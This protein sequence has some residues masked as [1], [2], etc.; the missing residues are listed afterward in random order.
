MQARKIQRVFRAYLEKKRKLV[1]E[2]R[3]KRFKDKELAGDDSSVDSHTTTAST[4]PV[5]SNRLGALLRPIVGLKDT[6]GRLGKLAGSNDVCVSQ[7]TF[8][9]YK[10]FFKG[11]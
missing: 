7:T 4:K 6:L 10:N 11:Y 9:L 1:E 8:S 5:K 2:M 3:A